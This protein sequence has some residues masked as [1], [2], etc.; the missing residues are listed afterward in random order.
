MAKEKF[1]FLVFPSEKLPFVSK[2]FTSFMIIWI[3]VKC[4]AGIGI[5]CWIVPTKFIS[6]NRITFLIYI[7]FF[8]T[9]DVKCE[10]MPL[11]SNES[12]RAPTFEK[13][14]ILTFLSVCKE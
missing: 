9:V 4:F 12:Q 10:H 13:N 2:R 1:F 14:E 3:G 8:E 5:W 11:K 6:L 7:R